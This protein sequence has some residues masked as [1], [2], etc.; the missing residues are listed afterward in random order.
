MNGSKSGSDC[1]SDFIEKGDNGQFLNEFFCENRWAIRAAIWVVAR[2]PNE[3]TIL[4]PLK[5]ILSISYLNFKASTEEF[6]FN[7]ER[8]G[9]GTGINQ[10]LNEV[11]TLLR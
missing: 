2:S 9:I 4:L 5:S 3:C 8:E 1:S 11:D 6:R 10:H 7:V